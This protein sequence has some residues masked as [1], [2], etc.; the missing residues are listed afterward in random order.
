MDMDG[1]GELEILAYHEDGYWENLSD[2]SGSSSKFSYRDKYFLNPE[3]SFALSVK[4]KNNLVSLGTSGF[5]IISSSGNIGL[6]SKLIQAI[7]PI[8]RISNLAE[9][10]GATSTTMDGM[11]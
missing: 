8:F 5:Q 1:D 10:I 9:S 6:S 11:I 3:S 4:Q 7:L 2:P